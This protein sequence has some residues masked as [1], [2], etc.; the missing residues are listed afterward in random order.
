MLDPKGKPHLRMPVDA[1]ELIKLADWSFALGAVMMLDDDEKVAVVG[2]QDVVHW[3]PQDVAEGL[4]RTGG[5]RYARP[6][7]C[8]GVDR[9]PALA[10]PAARKR[11]T[12]VERGR[13]CAKVKEELKRIRY[14]TREGGRNIKEIKADTQDFLVWQIAES[15]E[16]GK[17]DR[18][19]LL[20]PN[21]WGTGYPNLLLSKYF[22]VSQIRI[23]D[24]IT[25]YNRD[26][27]SQNLRRS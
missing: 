19:M 7:E 22:G 13:I 23:R 11:N 21:Q 3:L 1:K 4:I 25:A 14:M 9:K 12:A 26:V 15:E 24:Y 5:W 16:L 2:P 6:E 17:E 8:N 20:H 27:R 18:E 10:E